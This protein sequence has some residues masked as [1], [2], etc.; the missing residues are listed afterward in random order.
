MVKC[1][2]VPSG[3]SGALGS[4]LLTCP[5]FGSPLANISGIGFCIRVVQAFDLVQVFDL[6]RALDVVQVNTDGLL[7]YSCINI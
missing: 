7:Y 4:M 1:F 2:S 3:F 6:V 5:Q